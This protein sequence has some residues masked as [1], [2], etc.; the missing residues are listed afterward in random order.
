MVFLELRLDLGYILEL[1][2]GW[3]FK[4]LVFQRCQDSFL[5]ARDI[6]G[7]SMRLGQAIQTTLNVRQETDCSF[8]VSS[9]ILGFLSIFKNS[10]ASSPFEALYSACLSMFKMD[11]RPAVQMRWGPRVSL[12]SPQGI[13]TSFR[14]E[15]SKMILHSSHCRKIQP[16]FESLHLGVHSN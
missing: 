8:L 11:V 13:Q 6:S 12:W 3:T 7:I 16:S 15:S 14:F 10:Q 4:T 2:W 9:V 5:V 1:W